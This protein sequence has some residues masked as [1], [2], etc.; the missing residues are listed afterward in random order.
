MF[1]RCL[2][3]VLLLSPSIAAAGDNPE[4][5]AIKEADQADRQSSPAPAPENWRAVMQR[6]GERRNRVLEIL[7]EGQLK[8]AWDYFNAAIVLQHGSSAEDIR[9]AHSLSTIAITLDPEHKRAKWLVAASWDRLMLRFE[10]PQW[11]GTQ[12]VRDASGKFSLYPVDPNAVTD[13]DRVALG[14]PTLAEAQ[15]RA[16]SRNGSR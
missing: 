1:T 10:Q 16:E 15:A 5:R 3:L 12:S 7:K 9:L 14:V 8:T 2:F 6:D 13:T 11:Y 4:L